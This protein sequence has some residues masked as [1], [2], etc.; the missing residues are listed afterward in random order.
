[1]N[2]KFTLCLLL[3][4]A[5]AFLFGVAQLFKWRFEGGDVYPAYSSLRADPLG[6]S[7]YYE[8]LERIPGLSVRRDYSTANELPT[9]RNIAYLHLAATSSDWNKLPQ[10]TFNEIQS[11]L[12]RGGRLV[13]TLLPETVEPYKSS[14]RNN[15]RKRT[16]SS[17]R[18]KKESESDKSDDETDSKSEKPSKEP[19]KN[20]DENS[21]DELDGAF[22]FVSLKERWGIDFKFNPLKSDGDKYEPVTVENNEEPT[23]PKTMSWHSGMVFSKLSDAWRVV[24]ARKS[25]PVLIERKF[26]QGTVVFSTDSYF[27]SNEALQKERNAAILAWLIGPAREIVFDEAHLGIT[28]EGGVAAL[29]RQYNLHG[30]VIGLLFLS[31]L[32]IW[33]NSVSLVPA[34][35]S[36]KPEPFVVGKDSTAGFVN[37]LRRNIPASDLIKTCFSEWRKSQTKDRF[38]EAKIKRV[39]ELIS[40]Q[41]QGQN[42][43]ATYL[44]VCRALKENREIRITD[45]EP[46]S[47]T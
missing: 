12:A 47:N 14:Y 30:L 19:K 37:L 36:A 13:I 25:N 7:A 42:P 38:S 45:A 32:F 24:Y 21:D 41:D 4:C 6:S 23:L 34:H 2:R 5:L 17:T 28:Q 27:L 40:T 1:M 29:V 18:K 43:A 15:S 9:G 31:G 46:K 33:K 10:S 20:D 39:T 11:F 22:R 3:A 44:E 26:G 16:D 35:E 8:S